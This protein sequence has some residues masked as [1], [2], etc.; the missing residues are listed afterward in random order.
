MKHTT[1]KICKLDV[2]YIKTFWEWKI[3]YSFLKKKVY[4]KSKV[5]KN[6]KDL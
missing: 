3:R 6:K 1:I 2:F 5:G 4:G